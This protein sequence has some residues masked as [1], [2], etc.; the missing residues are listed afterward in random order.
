[1][2]AMRVAIAGSNTLAVLIAYHMQQNTNYHFV[3]LSRYVSAI[4]YS[5]S[6]STQSAH[7]SQERPALSAREFPVLVVDYSDPQ[8]LHHALMGVDVVVST[9]TGAP[10]IALI[11][12]AASQGV[13]RFAPA[14]FGSFPSTATPEDAAADPLDRGRAL[15]TQLLQYYNASQGMQYSLFIC[16]VL[17]ERFS[18]GGLRTH[19]LGLDAPA[20][21]EGD[22]IVDVRNL[23]AEA[24]VWDADGDEVEVC[25]TSVQDVALFVVEALG[26]KEWP[27]VQ[28]MVG[29]RMKV[30]KLVQTVEEVRSACAHCPTHLGLPL[31]VPLANAHLNELTRPPTDANMTR[32]VSHDMGSLQ[33]E[34]CLAMS[35]NDLPR[36]H[37]A[38]THIAT[39]VGRF[40]FGSP[41]LNRRFTH[42]RPTK[43]RDWLATA[44]GG[45]PLPG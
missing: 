38:A 9:V 44:W 36:Q 21:E 42:V 34:Y 31:L 45:M 40:T 18:P 14:E 37:R 32:S 23:I 41:S 39:A 22:Y 10:Q 29:E 5:D 4:Q 17:Y 35:L 24:P 43:F 1:M 25:M 13:S 7:A 19:W 12:A 33:S 26:L 8:T 2:A 16:G 20:M 30:T 27:L 6:L 3:I 28:T 15:A 11:H